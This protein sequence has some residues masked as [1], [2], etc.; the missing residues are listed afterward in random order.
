MSTKRS[1]DPQDIVTLAY[2]LGSGTDEASYRSAVSRAYYGVFLIAREHLR[3]RAKRGENI[4]G[5]VVQELR[6]RDN[7]IGNQLDKMRK[8]RNQADYDIGPSDSGV[9]L[10]AQR[11]RQVEPILRSLPSRVKR[12]SP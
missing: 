11:W 10:W 8:L 5:K 1:F 2:M 12:L 7:T 9:G 4:H 3:V 6:M